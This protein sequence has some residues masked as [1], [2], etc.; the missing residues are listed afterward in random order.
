MQQTVEERNRVVEENMGLV[1]WVVRTMAGPAL[2]RTGGYWDKD[3]LIQWGCLGLMRAA[4]T[5]EA[6]RAAFS[7]YARRCIKTAIS[8][9]MREANRTFYNASVAGQELRTV[10][11]DAER[12]TPDVTALDAELV[13]AREE[14]LRA[15]A[16]LPVEL[17]RSLCARV[18]DTGMSIALVRGLVDLWLDRSIVSISHGALLELYYFKG[19]SAEYIAE[20]FGSTHDSIRT[21]LKN[22]RN[23]LRR[24]PRG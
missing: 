19:Q 22:A 14:L 9:G 20:Q 3:D 13:E 12:D 18:L 6:E 21:R 11:Y 23:A 10:A 2:A 4:E 8:N 24:R 7:T 16:P 1:H 17:Q 15:L 5:Y